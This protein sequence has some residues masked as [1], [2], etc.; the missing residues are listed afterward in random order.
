MEET[1][2]KILALLFLICMAQIAFAQND[3]ADLLR[4]AI[5]EEEANQD[6]GKAM[7]AYNDILMQYEEHRVIAATALFHLAD[8]YRKQGKKEPAIAAYKRLLREFPEQVKLADA[9]R[10]YLAST[11]NIRPQ[12]D[13]EPE[14]QARGI[15]Q[16]LEAMQA[17]AMRDE[18]YRKVQIEGLEKRFEMIL[19][20]IELT[21]RQ[22]QETRKA[23]DSGS[24]SPMDLYPL[25]K[26]LLSLQEQRD[27]MQIEL[28]YFRNY[29]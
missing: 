11:Y 28:K 4:K 5:V 19:R 18:T 2:K 26:E 7:A 12:Q 20:K 3:M 10:N 23:V 29:K 22:I 9:S 13:T 14:K 21:E 15:V 25:E 17:E 16:Q 8:C 24:L 1:M 6:L 27:A